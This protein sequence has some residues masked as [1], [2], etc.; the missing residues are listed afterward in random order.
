MSLA[1]SAALELIYA[2]EFHPITWKEIRPSISVRNPHPTQP[3]TATTT[4]NSHTE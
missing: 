3:T 4:K 2:L 1:Y